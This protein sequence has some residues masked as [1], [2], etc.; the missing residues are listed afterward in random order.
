MIFKEIDCDILDNDIIKKDTCIIYDLGKDIDIDIIRFNDKNVVVSI[1]KD[2]EK[3]VVCDKTLF[4]FYE[5]YT[6]V[7][8]Y[9]TKELRF[10]KF[11]NLSHELDIKIFKRKI[12]LIIMP[13][14][15]SGLGD[16]IIA[17]LNAIYLARHTNLKFGFLWSEL[18]VDDF[19]DIV[20]KEDLFEKEFLFNH[21]Y[22][23]K[24][25][26]WSWSNLSLPRLTLKEYE[27]KENFTQTFGYFMGHGFLNVANLPDNYLTEYKIL[28][29]ELPFKKELKSLMQDMNEK[30]KKLGDFVVIHIRSGD[31]VYGKRMW[32]AH[33]NFILFKAMPTEIAL[34]LIILNF[35]KKVFLAY[36]DEE[37]ALNLKTYIKEKYN[38]EIYLIR[39]FIDA[40]LDK[41]KQTFSE[42]IF[43]SNAKEIYSGGSGFSRL[44]SAIGSTKYPTHYNTIFKQEKIF[45]IINKNFATIKIHYLQ[46]VYSTIV[47]YIF[48]RKLNKDE[49]A[50]QELLLRGLDFDK[51]PFLLCL[52]IDSCLKVYDFEKASFYLKQIKLDIFKKY[53]FMLNYDIFLKYCETRFVNALKTTIQKPI[54]NDLCKTFFCIYG[55]SVVIVKNHLSYKFGKIL[56]ENSHSFISCLKIPYLLF[57]TAINHKNLDYLDAS[58]PLKYYSDYQEALKIQKYFTYKLGSAWIKAYKN[59]WRLSLLKFIFK[60]IKGLK[61]RYKKN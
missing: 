42:L 56:I 13:I 21:C 2:D 6:E 36:E 1:A 55:M 15:N 46:N 8:L 16:R 57:A 54:N 25:F 29:Y 38:K 53:Y 60:D 32:L 27:K 61:K 11:E 41:F 4:K 35:D 52:V 47:L 5:E 40:K 34:E 14:H 10:I 43:M 39:T 50:I 17:I 22:D 3:F 9:A 45:D 18:K 24:E 12:N 49:K 28:F 59:K 58:I 31:I 30:A 37:Q 23:E 20:K 48:A 19:I 51:H 33:E 7:Q 26:K 44:A